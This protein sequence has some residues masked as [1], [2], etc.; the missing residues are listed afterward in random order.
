VTKERA[1]EERTGEFAVER[2]GPEA[3]EAIHDLWRRAELPFKPRGRDA[4]ALFRKRIAEGWDRCFGIRDDDRLIGVVVATHDGRKG[5]INRLAIDPAWRRRGLA[6]R[7]IEAAEAHLKEEGIRIVAA[8]IEDYNTASL[9][10]FQKLRYR[11]HRD[12][13]YLSKREDE[14]V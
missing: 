11:L 9:A 7:L 1:E 2:L 3:V 14:D 4:L 10:L 5:W 12:I 13:F 8:L 6:K